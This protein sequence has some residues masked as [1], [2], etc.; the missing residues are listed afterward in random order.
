[1]NKDLSNLHRPVCPRSAAAGTPL[2][3][4]QV[5]FFRVNGYLAGVRLLDDGRVA[6]L[7]EELAELMGPRYAADPR[8]YEYHR[9]E[10]GDDSRRLFHAL[11]AWRIAPAF[12]DLI[13]HPP[14]VAAAERLLGGPVRLWHD[15]LFVKPPGEGGIVAW[16][17][18]YSY[19]TRTR[20]MAHLTC[21]I[22]LDDAT[23]ENGC[24]QYVPG[25]HRWP[26]LPRGKLA[27]DMDAVLSVLTPEQRAEFKPVAAELKAGEASFHHPM[28]V[29]GS[30][31]NRSDRPRRGAVINVMLD[32]VCSDTDEPLLE[33][34]PVVPRGQK[35]EGRF[36]PRLSL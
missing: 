4:D 21:W 36:F 30:Y 34:V 5:E 14:F 16:H 15:Q 23:V 32:G 31:P 9:N 26:L 22:A 18:D 24:L 19:W 27:D 3:N 17:Q 8:F 33:G 11:G 6:E 1:M 7:N 10:S 20:P 35:I 25:S 13:Y 28:L 2:T 12:H 29:H